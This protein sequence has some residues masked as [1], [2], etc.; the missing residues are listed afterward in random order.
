MHLKFKTIP[1]QKQLEAVKHFYD[2]FKIDRSAV[3]KPDLSE[4]NV[5]LGYNLMREEN[6]E[7]L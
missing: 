4:C 2:V 5:I 3:L 1:M 7:Y 6:E